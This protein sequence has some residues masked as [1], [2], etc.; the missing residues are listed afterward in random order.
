[1]VIPEVTLSELRRD[2]CEDTTCM[3][4]RLAATR[5]KTHEQ[6]SE[7]LD[8]LISENHPVVKGKQS[9]LGIG[10]SSWL[11]LMCGL[12][13]PKNYNS[14]SVILSEPFN[15]DLIPLERGSKR[16]TRSLNRNMSKNLSISLDS[17]GSSQSLLNRD[18]NDVITEIVMKSG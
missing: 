4:H 3:S 1:M 12:N 16:T 14:L 11:A 9:M 17:Q 10:Q 15:R 13:S 5:E 2:Q 18:L 8:Y 7:E 6:V